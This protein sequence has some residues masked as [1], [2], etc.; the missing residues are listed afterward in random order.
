MLKLNVDIRKIRTGTLLKDYGGYYTVVGFSSSILTSAT[1]MIVVPTIMKPTMHDVEVNIKDVFTI[2]V[3][4]EDKCFNF[5]NFDDIDYDYFSEEQ[6]EL[7]LIKYNFTFPP[8]LYRL[9]IKIVTAGNIKE[10]RYYQDFLLLFSRVT[11][12]YQ[13]V[14]GQLVSIDLLDKDL[15]LEYMNKRFIE[16][17]F[18]PENDVRVFCS[19]KTNVIIRKS[20]QL[21]EIDKGYINE[22]Y[23]QLS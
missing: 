12:F 16:Y 2:F 6:S 11:P 15:L 18:H 3:L 14:H 8:L 17:N 23:N 7:L 4:N 21:V 10:G 20:T 9:P 5:F 22:F 19:D 1:G 13:C